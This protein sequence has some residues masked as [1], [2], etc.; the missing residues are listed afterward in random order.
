MKK[1]YF[2]KNALAKTHKKKRNSLKLWKVLKKQINQGNCQHN[3]LNSVLT[4]P[5]L[6]Y[7]VFLFF[8]SLCRC[9]GV[10]SSNLLSLMKFF[11]CRI[12]KKI[13]SAWYR[14]YITRQTF[15]FFWD[16]PFISLRFKLHLIYLKRPHT[17][18]CAKAPPSARLPV[19]VIHCRESTAVAGVVA[20][21]VVDK[22]G[23]NS[24]KDEHS[25]S[26]LALVVSVTLPLISQ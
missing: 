7:F 15:S 11:Q 5:P 20:S 26:A 21:T 17:L 10:R 2:E 8:F 13:L 18:L 12:K 19:K 25:K 1:K 22:N 16:L 4:Q 6:K 14:P 24:V 3:L 9:T 23:R